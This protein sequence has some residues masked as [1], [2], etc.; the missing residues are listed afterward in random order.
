MNK[1]LIFSSA[2]LLLTAVIVYLF[3]NPLPDGMPSVSGILIT[4]RLRIYA[5]ASGVVKELPYSIGQ[6]VKRGR[7]LVRMDPVELKKTI[8]R[9]SAE[10]REA[11]KKSEAA[12][13]EYKKLFNLY[14][15][16]K[17]TKQLLDQARASADS[18]Y[19]RYLDKK[20]ATD[21]LN[22]VLGSTSIYAR[23][24]SEI[25]SQDV[26][27]VQTVK[28]VLFLLAVEFPDRFILAAA[29]PREFA[30]AVRESD[31]V[32]IHVSGAS[33]E[34]AAAKIA[35]VSTSEVKVVIFDRSGVLRP[36][37]KVKAVFPAS[38]E[39]INSNRGKV[40]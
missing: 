27:V 39:R 5:P 12:A 33:L 14:E 18:L 35:E 10:E 19:R 30:S 4:Q 13:Q 11:L 34:A 9:T 29:L 24:D 21:A 38:A 1:K 6:K 37:Q 8:K 36:G 26:S 7:L 25:I 28:R 15:T 20:R 40:R 31:I 17:T 16:K 3:F 32:T 22:A 23:Y 2:V